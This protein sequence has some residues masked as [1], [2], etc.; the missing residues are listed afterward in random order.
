MILAKQYN[1]HIYVIFLFYI[2]HSEHYNA[3]FLDKEVYELKLFCRIQ[4]LEHK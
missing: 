2:N 4:E 1:I 3:Y